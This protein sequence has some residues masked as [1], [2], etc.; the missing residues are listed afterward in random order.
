MVSP[1]I[2]GEIF[3][4]RVNTYN[5][6]NFRP[7]VSRNVKSNIYGTETVTYKSYLVPTEIKQIE[8]LTIFK[9]TI[10]QWICCNCPCKL[11]KTFIP[12]LGFI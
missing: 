9:K 6:R 10:K 4:L 1:P 11:C 12:N 3:C 2:M 8:S 5:L 7:I